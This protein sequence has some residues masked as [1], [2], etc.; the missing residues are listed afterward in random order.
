[1]SVKTIEFDSD[2]SAG[3]ADWNYISSD[4]CASKITDLSIVKILQTC[5]WT[6]TERCPYLKIGTIKVR[7]GQIF[8]RSPGGIGLKIV[9]QNKYN[10]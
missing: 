2:E 6:E 1:M 10:L 5:C 3:S 9:N 8:S 7:Y 4:I